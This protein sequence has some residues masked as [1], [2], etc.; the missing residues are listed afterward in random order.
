MATKSHIFIRPKYVAVILESLAGAGKIGVWTGRGKR[1]QDA[2]GKGGIR[3]MGSG[4]LGGATVRA[5]DLR[6]GGRGFDSRSGRY[7]AT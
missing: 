6:S 5:S 4:W 3:G 7:Q 1:R 2:K